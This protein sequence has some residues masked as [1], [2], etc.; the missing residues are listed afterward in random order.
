MHITME[1]LSIL[2]IAIFAENKC[3]SPCPIFLKQ[4][5]KW[6]KSTIN[7]AAWIMH[8]IKKWKLNRLKQKNETRC[9]WYETVSLTLVSDFCQVNLYN[10]RSTNDMNLRHYRG[11]KLDCAA[12]HIPC[13]V[14]K[15]NQVTPIL[16]RARKNIPTRIEKCYLLTLFFPFESA[17]FF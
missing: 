16:D 4:L 14:P 13:C 10:G 1:L 8:F 9:Y 15:S 2:L 7:H 17:C 12:R 11:D 6:K 5:S 3:P